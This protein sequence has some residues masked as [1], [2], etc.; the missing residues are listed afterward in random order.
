MIFSFV[1]LVS[2]SMYA[3]WDELDKKINFVQIH[4]RLKHFTKLKSILNILIPSLVRDQIK[5]GKKN[6]SDSQG[7]V[8]IVFV[9]LESFDKLT[10]QYQGK[11]LIDL[12]DQIYN[13]F[14]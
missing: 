1:Y 2:L 7:N 5:D 6:F 8:T 9:D 4:G 10:Q 11:G 12:L 3:Y 13:T 14:D